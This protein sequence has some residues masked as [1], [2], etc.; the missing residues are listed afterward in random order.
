MLQC[1]GDFNI[2]LLQCEAREKFQEYFDIFLTN[3]L[4]PQITLPTRFSKKRA[5]LIDQIF[6]RPT[7]KMTN[8]KYHRNK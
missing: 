5:T 4:M 3:G 6:T 2:D 8:H 7:K 1:V